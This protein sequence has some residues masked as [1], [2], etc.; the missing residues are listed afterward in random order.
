[1]VLLRQKFNVL[2][3]PVRQYYYGVI[4]LNRYENTQTKNNL[5]RTFEDESHAH[6]RYLLYSRV[7]EQEGMGDAADFFNRAADEKLGQAGV[8]LN[9]MGMMGNTRQNLN[10]A[11]DGETVNQ[12]ALRKAASDASN[13]G[14]DD[15]SDKFILN[16]NISKNHENDGRRLLEEMDTADGQAAEAIFICRNCGY[17]HRGF[18]SPDFCPLCGVTRRFFRRLLWWL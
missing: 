4:N 5:K 17:R 1:M 15:I 12:E 8:W 14:F 10:F 2:K 7:A 6:T 11:I 13:E 16:M 9:E 18:R 3:P